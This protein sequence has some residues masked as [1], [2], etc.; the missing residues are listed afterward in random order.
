M[1]ICLNGTSSSG[2]TSISK[3]LQSKL[4]Y[5]FMEL[6]ID[7]LLKSLPQPVRLQ[8]YDEGYHNSQTYIKLI[9]SYHQSA[10]ALAWQEN[11]LI[12]DTMLLTWNAVNDFM[13]AMDG[14]KVVLIGIYCALSELKKRESAAEDKWVGQAAEEYGRIHHYFEYDHIVDST[15][16][17]TH[18]IASD[19]ADFIKKKDRFPGFYKTK[20]RLR[21]LRSETSFDGSVKYG[22]MESIHSVL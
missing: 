20:Q 3:A 22:N 5:D 9:K 2:K 12:L 13:K 19:I 4:G 10:Q 11:D 6:S 14:E 1:I 15:D 8:I 18:N 16:T 21:E 17:S 7:P